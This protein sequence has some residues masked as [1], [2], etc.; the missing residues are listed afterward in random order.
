MIIQKYLTA[1]RALE[2]TKNNGYVALIAV[3]TVGAVGTVL[4]TGVILLGLAWSRTSFT[5][6]Q[7]FQAKTLADACME[8]ALQ[9]IKNS[10]TFAGNGTL[11]FGQGSCNYTVTNN[12]AQNRSI[13]AK[14]FV[15][16]L[17][18]K[19]NVNLDKIAPAINITSWQEVE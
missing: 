8:D 13:V 1:M 6:Q 7:S 14:G 18:R 16:N 10:I 11:T 12:G 9:N 5:A 4:V 3:L 19:V 15:G 2:I 17:V